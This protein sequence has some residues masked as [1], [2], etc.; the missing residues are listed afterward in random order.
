VGDKLDAFLSK[1]SGFT[2]VS[3]RQ[4]PASCVRKRTTCRLLQV[5]DSIG[6]IQHLHQLKTAPHLTTAEISSSK[7]LSHK[8]SVPTTMTSPGLRGPSSKR[9]AAYRSCKTR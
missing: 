4:K 5:Y 3:N 9:C 8:P 1:K 6:S 2:V 7:Q